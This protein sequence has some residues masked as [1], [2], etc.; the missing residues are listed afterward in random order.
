MYV[1][2]DQINPLIAREIGKVIIAAAWA[3]GEIQEE[4]VA[5]LR[6]MLAEMP[7]LSIEDIAVLEDF[8]K[9]PVGP[10]ERRVAIDELHDLLRTGQERTYAIYWLERMIHAKGQVIE[11]E[12]LM[13]EEVVATLTPKRPRLMPLQSNEAEFV[14]EERERS[15]QDA[16]GQEALLGFLEKKIGA[17]LEA[18]LAVGMGEAPLRRLCLGAALLARVSRADNRISE[19]EVEFLVDFIQKGCAGSRDDAHRMARILLA[20]DMEELDAVRVC[21]ELQAQMGVD[22]RIGLLRMLFEI[23]QDG[24]ALKEEEVLQIVNL[25]ANLGLTQEQFQRELTVH[26]GAMPH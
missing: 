12:R 21:R 23:S 14:S 19:A 15:R 8:M 26:A 22:E 13:L 9:T 20:G 5:V 4:E 10:T 11:A 3:D 2:P 24:R 6:Q 17:V 1:S 25:A 18:G 7:D 16:L